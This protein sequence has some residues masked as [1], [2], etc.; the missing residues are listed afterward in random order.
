MDILEKR[1]YPTKE[2]AQLF[3]INPKSKDRPRDIKS[4]LNRLRYR[5]VY[6]KAKHGFYILATPS[7]NDDSCENQLKGIL[8]RYLE[9]DSQINT[10]AYAL[11]LR[12]LSEIAG[13]DCMP[14]AVRADILQ[15]AYG[16]RYCEATYRNW[17]SKLIDKGYAGKGAIGSMWRTEIVNGMRIRSQVPDGDSQ[18]AEYYAE[19][20]RLL[21]KYKALYQE[22]G[23]PTEEATK[24][25]W[26]RTIS[27]LWNKFH[28]CYYSCKTLT[29]FAFSDDDENFIQ[30]I[31]RLVD[32]IADNYTPPVPAVNVSS[33]A[34]NTADVVRNSS[35]SA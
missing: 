35:L 6:N 12:A 7:Q 21:T 25:R 32:E 14:W 27:D 9:L 11:F 20:S 34:I 2:L 3:S 17:F 13:F 22:M 29:L 26:K 16:L 8:F 23:L 19:R 30:E 33:E 18:M 28:C 10:I 31:Y 24:L 1:F 5:Y 15:E 4:K